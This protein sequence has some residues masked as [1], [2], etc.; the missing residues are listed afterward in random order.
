MQNL[1]R[2][3]ATSKFGGEYLQKGWRYSKSDQY[4]I[5]RDSSRVG[6]NKSGEVWSLKILMWNCT[7]L[8]HLFWKTIFRPLVGDAPP[9]FLHALENDQVLLVYPAPKMQA[10][11]TIFSKGG[12]K[13]AQN[14]AY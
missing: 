3:R 4:L 11:L 10:P 5:Y 12:Q 7:H 14:V 1:A 8:K 6:R 2:F 13:L 9:N